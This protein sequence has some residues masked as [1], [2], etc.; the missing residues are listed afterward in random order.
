VETVNFFSIKEV[1]ALTGIKAHTLRIWEQ[2]YAM[3]APRRTETNIRYYDEQD[4]KKLLNVSLLNR[5]G[6][7]ISEIAE[8]SETAMKN[9]V[10][11]LSQEKGDFENQMQALTLTM[12][13][14][15]EAAFDK[16]IATS[17]LQMGLEKTMINVVF[18]FFRSIGIMWQTGSI[19]PAHEHFITNI[20]RQKL[21]VAIDGQPINGDNWS[22]KFMLYLPEGEFHEIGLLFANYA[23]R[24]RGGKVIYLGS[25]VPFGDLKVV[26]DVYK[27]DYLFTVITSP[28]LNGESVQLYLDKLSQRFKETIIFVSGAFV[29]NEPALKLPANMRLVQDFKE[30][31]SLVSENA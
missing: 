14:L 3:I 30:M 29:L 16:L 22:K 24:V 17:I 25:S 8:M 31:L 11:Q 27:P 5:N 19:N 7:K 20:I 6:Y 9:A 10:L 26:F 18:P 13:E 23:I 21:I 15:N 2:R 1:E 12:L 4:L 28:L